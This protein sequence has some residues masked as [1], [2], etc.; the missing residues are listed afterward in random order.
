MEKK[1]NR[2]LL[3]PS[4]L[5][6]DFLRIIHRFSDNYAMIKEEYKNFIRVWTGDPEFA[7]GRRLKNGLH[8]VPRGQTAEEVR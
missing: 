2:C 7:D 3:C 5:F 8:S 1:V 4:A 6:A